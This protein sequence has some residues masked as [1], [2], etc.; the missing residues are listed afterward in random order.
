MP[1]KPELLSELM[2]MEQAL[3]AT[4]VSPDLWFGN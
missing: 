1:G 4:V 3:E 2:W